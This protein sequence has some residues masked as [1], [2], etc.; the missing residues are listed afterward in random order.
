VAS[1]PSPTPLG[2]ERAA[3]HASLLASLSPEERAVVDLV[4][5][6]LHNKEIAATLYLSVRTV[7]LRLT[8]IYRKVGARSRAHLVSLMS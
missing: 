3:Q 2:D 8:H 6:G 1:A 7:E 4:V 5:R